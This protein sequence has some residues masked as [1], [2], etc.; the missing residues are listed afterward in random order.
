M[1]FVLNNQL[2][3]QGLGWRRVIQTLSGD[4]L[5]SLAS[6]S[7]AGSGRNVREMGM[8][9]KTSKTGAVDLLY[10]PIRIEKQ[11]REARQLFSESDTRNSSTLG[12]L[13]PGF[14]APWLVS[15]L[16]TLQQDDDDITPSVEAGCAA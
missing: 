1:V 10:E 4:F 11:N 8:N 5:G 15:W 14:E 16:R 13:L 6:Q 9:L 12:S 7:T 2:L 3:G